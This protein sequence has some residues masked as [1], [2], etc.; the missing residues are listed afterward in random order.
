[1][2]EKSLEEKIQEVLPN[3]KPVDKRNFF[4]RN[5]KLIIATILIL[6]ILYVAVNIYI[7][8]ALPNIYTRI[9]SLP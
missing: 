2:E 5:K 4:Q 8:V 1:M 6:S 7:R 3:Q 9:N